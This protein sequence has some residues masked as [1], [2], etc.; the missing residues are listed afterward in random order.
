MQ[1]PLEIAWP[2]EQHLWQTP[3]C[4][5]TEHVSHGVCSYKKLAEDVSP[6]SQI[7]CADGSIVLEVL[8]TNPKAGTVLCKCLNNAT[9]GCGRSLRACMVQHVAPAGP[10]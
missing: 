9:L 6:G 3:A 8:S 4:A 2:Y 7:L 1:R 10:P 5:Q